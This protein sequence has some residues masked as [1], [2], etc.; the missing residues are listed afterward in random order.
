[1]AGPS[2]GRK[3]RQAAVHEWLRQFGFFPINA[4]ESLWGERETR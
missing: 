4:D 1:M 2:I 3:S